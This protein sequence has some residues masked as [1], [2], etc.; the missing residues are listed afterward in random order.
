M[1]KK[2][3][4]KKRATPPCGDEWLRDIWTWRETHERGTY[5]WVAEKTPG[6]ERSPPR[7]RRSGLNSDGSYSYF[8]YRD[9]RAVAVVHDLETAKTACA[10]GPNPKLSDAVIRYVDEHPGEVPPF[11][12]LTEAERR[13]ARSQYPYAV[14]G[15][16]KVRAALER[17][18]RGDAGDDADEG[19]ARLREELARSGTAPRGGKRAAVPPKRSGEAA[20]SREGVMRRIRDGNPK[21]VGSGAYKR[22]EY[23]FEHCARGSTVA[24]YE[25]A[26]GNPETLANA[27]RAGYVKIDEFPVAPPRKPGQPP[28]VLGMEIGEES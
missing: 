26:K 1:A 28:R 2:A 9:G 6:D 8:C 12:L 3:S 25:E 24:Q 5:E 19:T 13:A 7:V 22:W 14:P 11:L 15:A 23:M 10:R 20:P 18:N 21:K 17:G 16:A 4:P 27:V